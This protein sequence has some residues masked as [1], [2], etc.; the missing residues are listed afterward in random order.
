MDK[1]QKYII[2]K[3]AKGQVYAA[4]PLYPRKDGGKFDFDNPESLTQQDLE[5]LHSNELT[6]FVYKMPLVYNGQSKKKAVSKK[7]KE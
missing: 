5:Y 4:K 1:H 7:E 3:V 6:P 2:T